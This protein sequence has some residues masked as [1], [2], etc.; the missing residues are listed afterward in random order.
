[1]DFFYCFYISLCNLVYYKEILAQNRNETKKKRIA[2]AMFYMDNTE[3]KYFFI[4]RH[5]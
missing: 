5:M 3:N 4:E 1:M 2:S